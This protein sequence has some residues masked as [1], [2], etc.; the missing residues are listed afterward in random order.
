[1][2]R[3]ILLLVL[4]S[5]KLIWSQNFEKIDSLIENS[6]KLK[7]FPGAQVYLKNSDYTY[8]K[9]YGFHTYDSLIK[10]E[11]DHL[12]D[13]ASITKT[14]AA[15]LAIMKL[16]DEKKLKLD[17]VISKNIKQ[18]RGSNK[19]KSNFHEL[20]IH[21]SGWI[22]YISHQLALI[23]KSGKL[24]SRFIDY[25]SSKNMTQ[26]ANNLFIKKSYYNKIIR[27][28]KRTKIKSKGEYLYSGLFFCLVP[29]IV[30]N[31]SGKSFQNY[32]S[33]NFYS[34]IGVSLMFNPAK[35]YEL[36]KIVPTENDVTFRKQLIRGY[37]HDETAAI[38]GGISGNAGLFG[39]ANDVGKISELLLN[40]GK[41]KGEQILN[42]ST[43]QY[44]S[45]PENYKNE[46]SVRGLGFDKPRMTS[47][48]NI[49]PSQ[50]LSD[51]SYGHTGFT[52]TFFW[53]DPEKET[54]IVLL[55]NRVYPTRSYENLYDL[56]VRRK[57]IDLII[58][59]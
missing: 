31:I 26:L 2:T 56:D 37:V 53:I 34:K 47:S 55:T 43:I 16:Y 23:K 12:Y 22:P 29:E 28:I 40:K 13:L 39:S 48:G 5:S 54:V 51:L 45:N 35:N 7:A 21:Q 25:E 4:F 49:S 33:E 57:L 11:Q 20:L 6:I 15:T 10:V 58:E 36:N 41:F 52:G 46:R 44:F 17:E 14:L 3:I 1:M 9:S 50:K 59:N 8:S 24:K 42:K 27:K 19:K 32:L 18:L 38:M 30:E